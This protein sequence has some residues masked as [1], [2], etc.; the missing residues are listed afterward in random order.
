LSE[1]EF[2]LRGKNKGGG[3][4][5]G[6]GSYDDDCRSKDIGASNISQN[7][8][9]TSCAEIEEKEE[10]EEKVKE[11]VEEDHEDEREEYCSHVNNE[12]ENVMLRSK[13]KQR[14]SNVCVTKLKV[15]CLFLFL[16]LFLFNLYVRFSII[17][18][19]F[20]QIF[21]LLCLAYLYYI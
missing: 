9:V 18:P 15:D 8:F 17:I 20:L 13:T 1:L 21:S 5:H 10:K 3:F 16:S 6:G 4:I 19:F 7:K 14:A 2:Y 11:E 12:D